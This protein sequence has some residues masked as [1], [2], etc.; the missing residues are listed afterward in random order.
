MHKIMEKI[1]FVI[2]LALILDEAN[3]QGFGVVYKPL[4]PVPHEEFVIPPDPMEIA[5]ERA[6]AEAI[7]K[8]SNNISNNTK[9]I[10]FDDTTLNFFKVRHV[11]EKENITVSD[12]TYSE[13]RRFI[14][15]SNYIIDEKNNYVWDIK[16]KEYDS[17]NIG[18]TIRCTRD[19]KYGIY[20]FI[21]MDGSE[22]AEYFED[23]NKRIESYCFY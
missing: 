22:I 8:A 10:D 13:S 18:M 1:L 15:R 7:Y 2:M 23:E 12:D 19:D 11:I 6:K 16:K 3:A 17:E 9:S 21:K 14:I 20:F 5:I 4:P